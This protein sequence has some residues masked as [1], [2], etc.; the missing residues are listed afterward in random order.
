MHILLT[1]LLYLI[2]A[3]LRRSWPRGP[4]RQNVPETDVI[5][6]RNSHKD[7]YLTDLNPKCRGAAPIQAKCLLSGT[8]ESR[9]I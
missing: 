5:I 4:I 8:L 9:S 7:I 1:N 2:A 3:V 6:Q